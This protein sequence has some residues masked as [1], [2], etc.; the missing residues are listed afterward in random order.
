LTRK[1]RRHEVY[2]GKRP[3][4]ADVVLQWRVREVGAENAL[5]PSVDLAKEHSLV[6]SLMEAE[7]DASDTSE[8]PGDG[9]ARAR[10]TRG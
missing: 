6:S 5:R 8:Q 3:E 4:L 9:Q 7:F 2:T 1:S 10:V